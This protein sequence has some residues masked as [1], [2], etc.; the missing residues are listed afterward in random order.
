[1]FEPVILGTAGKDVRCEGEGRNRGVV[2]RSQPPLFECRGER[3]LIDK[4]AGAVEQGCDP[5]DEFKLTGDGEKGA[6]G[7]DQT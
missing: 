1:M 5:V 4:E 3:V 6:A 2:H 7:N